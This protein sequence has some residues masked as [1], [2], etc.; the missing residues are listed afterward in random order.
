MDY[1][2]SEAGFA[3]LPPHL[4]CHRPP[5]HLLNLLQKAQIKRTRRVKRRG[6]TKKYHWATLWPWA[7]WRAPLALGNTSGARQRSPRWAT[8]TRRWL[9][10]GAATAPPPF[11]NLGPTLKRHETTGVEEAAFLSET[12]CDMKRPKDPNCLHS[13]AKH[14]NLTKC[15]RGNTTGQ[16]TTTGQRTA[17][18]EVSFSVYQPW[19]LTVTN[20]TPVTP[21]WHRF[22][23]KGL[24]PRDFSPSPWD[25]R[26]RERWESFRTSWRLM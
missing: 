21:R 1:T 2:D 8:T 19:C 11:S 16:A 15:S 10:R 5:P 23:T 6:E 7:V 25:L 22:T 20:D 18:V 14:G 26:W 4:L 12:T 17:P 9:C 24:L 3:L 13:A